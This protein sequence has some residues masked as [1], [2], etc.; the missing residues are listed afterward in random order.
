M[1]CRSKALRTRLTVGYRRI[2]DYLFTLCKFY[3]AAR[4]SSGHY[5]TG[6]HL[7]RVTDAVAALM[8]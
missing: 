1:C 6:M 7:A 4:H 8:M 3:P 5:P 2:A